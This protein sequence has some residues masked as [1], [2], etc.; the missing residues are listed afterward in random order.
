MRTLPVKSLIALALMTCTWSGAQAGW[1][2]RIGIGVPCWG[3]YYRPYY[4]YY[5][6]Y[7]YY[8][9][10]VVVAAPPPPV[11]IQSAV[12]PVQPA[13]V[14]AAPPAVSASASPSYQASQPA[15]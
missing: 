6:Y 8:P 4:G 10:A 2:V 14:S 3:P 5:G 12:V 9:P 15:P 1:G 13:P 7:G 11:V